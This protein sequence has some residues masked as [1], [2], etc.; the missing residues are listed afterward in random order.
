[1]KEQLDCERAVAAA[2]KVTFICL[3]KTPMLRGICIVGAIRCF[4]LLF[5]TYSIKGW[6]FRVLYYAGLYLIDS[7]QVRDFAVDPSTLANCIAG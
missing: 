5:K 2:L 7:D 6:V 3:I 1:M 4:F